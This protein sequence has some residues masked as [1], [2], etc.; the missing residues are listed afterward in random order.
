[1]AAQGQEETAMDHHP[2]RR[3]LFV[4][5]LIVGLALLGCA[6]VGSAQGTWSVISLP[7][8]PGEVLR[9]E[10]LA[11][12]SDGN[13]YVADPSSGLRIQKRD[14]QGNWSVVATAGTALGQVGYVTALAVDAAGNLYVAEWN[15]N[16]VDAAGKFY[17]VESN[18][19][20]RI[21]K[22]DAQGNWSVIATFGGALGQVSYVNAL[23]VDA[24]GNL[25][26]AD[27]YQ[28]HDRIQK[29][30]PQGNW[31][32]LAPQGA[33]ALA[34]DTV[35]NLFV[36]NWH[37]RRIE[38]RDAQGNWSVIATY[39]TAPGQVWFPAGLAVDAAGN[40][41]VAE[42][43]SD[44]RLQ[45]RDAQG[46][47][48]VIATRGNALGQV[49]GPTALAVDAAGNLYVADREY[50]IERIQKRDAQGNWSVLTTRY[51]D[52][53]GQVWFP[54]GLAVDAAGNLYVA[55]D[56]YDAWGYDVGSRIQKRDVQ[57]NWWV[58]ATYGGDLGQVDGVRA[59]AVDTAGNLYVVDGGH[60][61]QKRDL[62]G[63]W[64]L[65]DRPFSSY[66]PAHL[67]VDAAGNLYI[68]SAHVADEVESLCDP[69]VKSDAQGNWSEINPPSGRCP[70]ALAVDAAGNLYVVDYDLLQKRDAQGNW[71][72]IAPYGYALGQVYYPSALA[73]DAAGNLYVADNP[74]WPKDGGRIQKRDAQGNWSVVA[75]TGPALGQV[76]FGGDYS[77]GLAL[78]AAGNLYVADTYNHRVQ[79][80]APGP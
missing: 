29:R 55:E 48:S 38:K 16:A 26:V 41:Y 44:G 5:R 3:S 21:Q 53:A 15:G 33:A 34:V 62:Q 56:Q 54:A 42:Y 64:S 73:V 13:L 59:V 75:T 72:V 9:P 39:G 51:G 61:I 40:L 10:G 37:D 80:Y 65:V 78:D 49:Y 31:S 4:L 76:D 32:I 18:G 27:D 20:D 25:Y 45:K 52:T 47:W 7:Q 70:S 60:R 68:A 63:N 66:N 46:N 36:A 22:R 69:I 1:M 2:K 58:I 71:T 43:G 19:N 28:Y 14:A 12:D 17:F 24:A 23:A 6:R 79:K 30:D 57:G 11:V 50:P 35:G 8:K 74:N 77:G 67:A